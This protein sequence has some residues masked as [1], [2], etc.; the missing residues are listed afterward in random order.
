[1]NR[2]FLWNLFVCLALISG[3]ALA[4]NDCSPSEPYEV[5]EWI[6]LSGSADIVEQGVKAQDV[7]RVALELYEKREE[8]I[9]Q[10]CDNPTIFNILPSWRAI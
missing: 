7:P 1:M 10:A 3:Q 4:Q 9:D 2:T 8:L 6:Y 5:W